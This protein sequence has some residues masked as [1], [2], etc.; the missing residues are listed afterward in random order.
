MK[1][2]IKANS[3]NGSHDIGNEQYYKITKIDTK[4]DKEA[5]YGGGHTEQDV[6]EITRGYTFNGLFYERKGSRYIFIVE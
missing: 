4:T 3:E 6:K 1:R 2:V 5:N